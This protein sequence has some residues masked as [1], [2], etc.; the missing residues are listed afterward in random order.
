MAFND[1][2]YPSSLNELVSVMLQVNMADRP[3]IDGVLAQAR[4][5]L[6]IS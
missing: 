3:F 2:S 1:C 6:L 4:R 5:L